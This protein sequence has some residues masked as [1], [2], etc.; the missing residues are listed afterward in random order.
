M[1]V[2]KY[3]KVFIYG[4]NDKVLIEVIYTIKGYIN[5]DCVIQTLKLLKFKLSSN[6][7]DLVFYT[8]QILT[9]LFVLQL[10][11]NKIVRHISI[12]YKHGVTSGCCY[13]HFVKKQK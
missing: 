3:N 10:Y 5:Q 1:G 12:I 2:Q 6:D 4:E 9:R 11:K 8:Q 7:N 13:M